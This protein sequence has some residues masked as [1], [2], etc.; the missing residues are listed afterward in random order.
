MLNIK[1]YPNRKLYD[2]E[3]KQYITLDEIADLIRQGKEIRVTDNVTGEDL[4][5]VTLSQIIFEQ[6]KKQSGF[7]PRSVLTGLIQTGGDRINTLQ[8]NLMSSLGFLHQVD[9]EIKYRIE[10][11]INRGELAE[12]E[13]KQL[14]EKL[15]SRSNLVAHNPMIP[16]EELIKQVLA[17]QN[18]PSKND[19][20]RI[21][22]QL[23]ELATKLDELNQQSESL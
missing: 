12:R 10:T 16:S 2:T 6:E 23:D 14:L 21:D 17:K 5:A 8:R 9:E 7:L 22:E 3:A 1:R 11:L 4:T 20:D 15:L 19:M 13:G 18:I